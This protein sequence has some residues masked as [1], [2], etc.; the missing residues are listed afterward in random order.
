MITR[1]VASRSIKTV[2]RLKKDVNQI[3]TM[4]TN[5]EMKRKRDQSTLIDVRKK[6]RALSRTVKSQVNAI[7]MLTIDKQKLQAVNIKSQKKIT[8]LKNEMK[9]IS[10][11]LKKE[12]IASWLVINNLMTKAETVMND[13]HH[14]KFSVER[15]KQVL[16]DQ[17]SASKDREKKALREERIWSARILDR[18]EYLFSNLFLN[19]YLTQY[20]SDLTNS[21]LISSQI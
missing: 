13:V 16:A 10:D 3:K 1:K 18:R 21:F 14:L 4:K 20:V 6:H 11:L 7:T 9:M 19:Q 8:S 2:H 15:S 5:V 17:V 12:K